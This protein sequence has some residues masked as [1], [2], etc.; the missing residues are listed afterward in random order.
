MNDPNNPDIPNNHFD[1][2]LDRI[3]GGQERN[4]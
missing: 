1:L 2:S 4:R 3:S